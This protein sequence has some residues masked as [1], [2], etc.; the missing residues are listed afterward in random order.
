[1][2]GATPTLAEDKQARKAF[3][4]ALL[5]VYRRETGE[6]PT[7]NF[8][9]IINGYRQSTYCS[10]EE[11]GGRLEPGET[12]SNTE[13]GV[14]PL[15]W[16]RIDNVL[17]DDWMGLWWSS[18]RLLADAD[19]SIAMDGGLYRLGEKTHDFSR[20]RM[21]PAY[22][23]LRQADL[24]GSPEHP[25]ESSQKRTAGRS[26]DAKSVDPADT[27]ATAR[28]MSVNPVMAVLAHRHQVPQ[29]MPAA[30]AKRLPMMSV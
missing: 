8:G 1:M 25:S 15:D 29:V 27:V 11:R 14:G 16:S 17:L 23:V 22:F 30:V 2:S 7:A 5:A 28:R 12:E 10:G 4:D 3:E 19:T 13:D 21:S 6:S 20:G 9:R 24:S 18:P 26:K